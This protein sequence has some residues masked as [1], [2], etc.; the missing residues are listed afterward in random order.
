MASNVLVENNWFDQPTDGGSY[1]IVHQSR[2]RARSAE[3]LRSVT[4]RSRRNPDLQ[5]SP[6]YEGVED[7][8]G[9][10]GAIT[11][12]GQQGVAFTRELLGQPANAA[13]PTGF[14]LRPTL[15]TRAHSTS[16]SVR[17]SRRSAAGATESTDRSRHRRD[18]RP[19]ESLPTPAPTSARPSMLSLG[20]QIGREIRLVRDPCGS[21]GRRNVYGQLRG[22]VTASEARAGEPA[23]RATASAGPSSGL[24]YDAATRV[25]G[26]GTSS[27]YYVSPTAVGLGAIAIEHV[28]PGRA[29]ASRLQGGPRTSVREPAGR[30]TERRTAAS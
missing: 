3:L 14:P 26:V 28:F 8:L 21:R 2:S 10:S 18:R 25:V 1:A 13:R 16:T 22:R 7:Q 27:R 5:R 9:T 6:T 19:S 11:Y 30:R 4:T 15:S 23:L 20:G 17:G 12:C 24:V 29:G